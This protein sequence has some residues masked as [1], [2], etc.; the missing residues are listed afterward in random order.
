MSTVLSQVGDTLLWHLYKINTNTIHF[1]F[2]FMFFFLQRNQSQKCND[3][4]KN[5][6]D[7]YVLYAYYVPGIILGVGIQQ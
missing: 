2:H 1:L 3:I 5:S 6:F 7:K 4:L